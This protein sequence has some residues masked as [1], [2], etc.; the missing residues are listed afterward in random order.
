MTK[1]RFS[2]RDVLKGSMVAGVFY[3]SPVRA[4]APAPSAITPELIAAARKEGR[5]ALY[6]AVDLPVA[7][8]FAKA[9]QAKY[10]G[11]TVRVERTGAERCSSAS[12]RR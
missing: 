5:V 2:R 9:F 6:T 3:A 10:P 4:Q 11:I 8:Q 12:G 7:E 1:I